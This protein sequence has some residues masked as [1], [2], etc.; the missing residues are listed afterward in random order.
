MTLQYKKATS[1]NENVD[2]VL[3]QLISVINMYDSMR[4]S[5]SHLV[6]IVVILK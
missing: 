3:S 4:S 2:A 5:L 1:D 6:S